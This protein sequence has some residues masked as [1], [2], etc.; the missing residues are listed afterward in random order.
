MCI[1]VYYAA[2][3][4]RFEIIVYNPASMKCYGIKKKGLVVTSRTEIYHWDG[5]VK[6]MSIE[7]DREYVD[8]YVICNKSVVLA[9]CF[10]CA[11]MSPDAV[12]VVGMGS[13]SRHETY[14]TFAEANAVL[15]RELEKSIRQQEINLAE[16][17]GTLE[18]ARRLQ[19]S[20]E[21]E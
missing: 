17:K 21:S 5:A 7:P 3:K 15:I 6:V 1:P 19:E 20:V 14:D 2:L 18:K 11:P 9:R 4:Q 8:R 16:D 10:S 13:F 12:Y